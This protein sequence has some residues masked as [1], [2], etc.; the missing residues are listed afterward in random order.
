MRRSEFSDQLSLL[1]HLALPLLVASKELS[2]LIQEA[3]ALLP[4][5]QPEG[6]LC[7]AACGC[8][9]CGSLG[10][11]VFLCFVKMRVVLAV[12]LERDTKRMEEKKRKERKGEGNKKKKEARLI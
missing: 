5:A 12:P 2:N 11:A 9:G 4:P 1:P 6:G 10:W 8:H 7:R 3:G